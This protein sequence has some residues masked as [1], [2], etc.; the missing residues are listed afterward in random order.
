MLHRRRFFQSKHRNRWNR[1]SAVDQATHSDTQS[2]IL[3]YIGSDETNIL[4]VHPYTEEGRRKRFTRS[5]RLLWVSPLAGG[6]AAP[7]AC[8]AGAGGGAW[9]GVGVWLLLLLDARRTS[10][11]HVGQV[12]CL[13]NQERRQLGSWQEG[14]QVSDIVQ[15]KKKRRKWLNYLLFVTEVM[16]E[17]RNVVDGWSFALSTVP[18]ISTGPALSLLVLLVLVW[19][20]LFETIDLSL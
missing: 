2:I 7:L 18:H 5:C 8:A 6:A 14:E 9:A 4:S 16:M 19:E 17:A 15:G 10:M 12:C 20:L 13:W 1:D 3:L 11:R